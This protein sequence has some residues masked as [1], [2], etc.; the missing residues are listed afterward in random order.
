MV[1]RAGASET[2]LVAGSALDPLLADCIECRLDSWAPNGLTRQDMR[3]TDY[4]DLQSRRKLRAV[5]VG[6]GKGCRSVLHMVETDTLGRFRMEIVG[7]ADTDIDAPGMSYA[8]ELGIPIV[9]RDYREL[10]ELP[11]LDLIIELTGSN[12]LRDEI[13]RTRPKKVRMIDHFGARLFW[14]LHR[15]VEAIITQ[16]S[17]M[18]DRVEA[19]RERIAQ[20][21]DCIPDEIVVLDTEM[22]ILE[23][24]RNFLDNNSLRIEDVRGRRCY[25]VEQNIRGECQVAVDNCPF[26]RVMEEGKPR[27]IVRKHFSEKGNPRYAVIVAAPLTDSEGQIIGMIEM[28]RD[29]THRIMLEEELK[30]TEVRLQQIMQHAPMAMYVKNRNGQFMEVNPATC[31]LI[32]KEKHEIIGRTDFEILPRDTA[33]V[34]RKGDRKVFKSKERLSYESKVDFGDRTVFL[35]TTKF[36]IMGPTGLV[37]AVVGL[38]DDVTAQREA[39]AELDRTRVHLRN[40]LDNSP[41]VI[42]TTDLEGRIVSFNRGAEECLG[43]KSEEVIGMLASEFYGETEEREKLL[44]RVIKDGAVR[45][46][47]TKL[48]RKD[49]SQVPVSITLSQLQNEEGEMIGTVGISKDISQRK[50]LMHQIIQSERMAAVG[51]LAAG[52]AH[53]INNPLAVIGEIAGY[54]RDISSGGPGSEDA[55]LMLELNEGLPKIERQVSRGRKITS[56]LLTLARKTEARVH[57]TEIDEALD[58]ILPFLEKEAGLKRI[59][60][61]RDKEGTVSPVAVEEIQLQEIFINVIQNAIQ[62]KASRDHGNIWVSRREENRKVI[63]TIRDDGPGV[64]EEVRD[65]IFDPFVTTK[66]IGKGTGLGL[67][68]CYGII[69]RY[70]G[71]IRLYSKEG[72]GATFEVILPAAE[73]GDEESLQTSL[74]VGD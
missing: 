12:A 23:A 29:I 16:R 26:F 45:D 20:I 5:V 14:D 43:Y 58:E 18:R 51:R 13:E 64:P 38:S 65:R 44:R 52:V 49:G 9:T 27:S 63:V 56:R 39:Q 59:S 36:P 66:P 57:L 4:P 46:Y 8:R 33:E 71:E 40:V 28:T 10:Y 22:T 67:S 70:D 69:K 47:Q 61:H 7:V 48:H 41:A 53:E 17:E 1:I 19:E 31:S 3:E 30:A 21:F 34:L 37:E 2:G 68:I 15:A 50:S 74:K 6:G 72:E 11:D 24:N 73:R 35:S 32:G 60:L 54:L 62:A 55:D 42:M 25:E